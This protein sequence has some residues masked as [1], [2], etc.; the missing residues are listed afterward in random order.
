VTAFSVMLDTNAISELVRNPWGPIASRLEALG[1]SRACI[2]VLTAAELRYGVRKKG[3]ARLANTIE[4]V[5]KRIA[6]VDF[7]PPADHVY[8]EV[9][10]TLTRAGTPIGP[11]DTFIAAHALA[12]DL[13]LVT[14]NTREFER[15]PRLRVEN[16]LD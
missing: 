12:L 10:D 5:L 13:V 6:I 15:V 14:A 1:A 8:A 7:Q 9:R 11:I 3:S 16:W 4:G 2:S